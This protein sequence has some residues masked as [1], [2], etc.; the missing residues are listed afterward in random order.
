MAVPCKCINVI[1]PVATLQEKYPGGVAGDERVINSPSFC[2]DELVTRVGFMAPIDVKFWIDSL[3]EHGLVLLEHGT[4]ADIA[5]VDMLDGL[6]APCTWLGTD[7]ID[8][9]RWAWLEGGRPRPL[10]TPA[11]RWT[12]SPRTATARLARK[13]SG[14]KLSPDSTPMLT[15]SPLQMGMEHR[16][17]A[18]DE[19]RGEQLLR[20]FLADW[21]SARGV[22]TAGPATDDADEP[23]EDAPEGE[24]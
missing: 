13:P 5:V 7:V 23:P 12:R 3:E 4:F 14:T 10:T 2:N 24:T 16:T 19:P 18:A 11:G 20:R 15:G 8:G 9:V 1:V 6:T 22:E 21:A 17:M